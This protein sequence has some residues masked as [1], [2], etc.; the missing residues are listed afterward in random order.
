M[1]APASSQDPDETRLTECPIPYHRRIDAS[2]RRPSDVELLRERLARDRLVV[3]QGAQAGAGATRLAAEL[4]HEEAA[5]GARV[6][7]LPY[8]TSSML[9]AAADVVDSLKLPSAGHLRMPWVGQDDA[10][11]AMWSELE[12]TGPL[13]VVLEG[14]WAQ[15]PVEPWLSPHPHVRVLAIRDAGDVSDDSTRIFPVPPLDRSVITRMLRDACQRIDV[16]DV[17][18]LDSLFAN[19]AL[20]A[21][22]AHALLTSGDVPDVKGWVAPREGAAEVVLTCAISRLLSGET[23]HAIAAPL[24]LLRVLVLLDAEPVPLELLAAILSHAPGG[25]LTIANL[26]EAV[27]ML[28]AS[29]LVSRT[30]FGELVAHIRVLRVARD[31]FGETVVPWTHPVAAGL[32]D[33][34]DAIPHIELRRRRRL[35]PHARRL[36]RCDFE[37]RVSAS[38]LAKI[39][40]A[41]SGDGAFRKV[42]GDLEARKAVELARSVEAAPGELTVEALMRLSLVLTEMGEH[43]EAKDVSRQAVEVAEQVEGVDG[44]LVARALDAHARSTYFGGSSY[45]SSE[46]QAPGERALAIREKAWGPEDPRLAEDIFGLAGGLAVR[47]EHDEAIVLFRRAARLAERGDPHVLTGCLEALA[48][49]LGRVGNTAEALA[50]T[51][52]VLALYRDRKDPAD[53]RHVVFTVQSALNLFEGVAGRTHVVALVDEVLAWPW[54]RGDSEQSETVGRLRAVRA[55]ALDGLGRHAEAVEEAERALLLLG[56]RQDYV[57]ERLRKILE[58]GP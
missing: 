55:Q 48:R 56:P 38:L 43:A 35:A 49:A 13:L 51:W 45:K 54:D 12:A 41:V 34:L 1:S 17:A 33:R 47:G 50:V 30:V 53:R 42:M 46:S 2:L 9:E 39:G 11:R 5:A 18:A 28:E 40:M 4:A 19:D 52:R 3:L 44:L 10:M 6:L 26:S 57:R 22:V 25:P 7:C 21:D 29:R 16:A 23:T 58:A 8:R 27:G 31:L 14:A 32:R 37:G 20:S 36:L 24:A 15:A